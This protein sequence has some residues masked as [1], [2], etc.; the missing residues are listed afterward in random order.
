MPNHVPPPAS[1]PAAT[2][3]RYPALPIRDPSV[4]NPSAPKG[5][6]PAPR[7]LRGIAS[8]AAATAGPIHDCAPGGAAS[9][10]RFR[11]PPPPSTAR[12]RVLQFAAAASTTTTITERCRGASWHYYFWRETFSSLLLPPRL[13]RPFSW[14]GCRSPRPSRHPRRHCSPDFACCPPAPVLASSMDRADPSPWSC[15]HRRRRGLGRSPRRWKCPYLR[16]SCLWEHYQE[17]AERDQAQDRFLAHSPI[18]PSPP[19]WSSRKRWGTTARPSLAIG[20]GESA[21]KER[22]MDRRVPGVADQYRLQKHLM[23]LMMLRP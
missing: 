18:R 20:R 17:K 5:T 19:S 7:A 3:G 14:P 13:C 4:P 12:T 1:A 21:T 10:R 15:L 11:S 23:C 2:P 9:D 8:A 6:L 22:P 16:W